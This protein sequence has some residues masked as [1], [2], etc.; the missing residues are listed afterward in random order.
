V[1]M[2]AVGHQKTLDV[3]S[4]YVRDADGAREGFL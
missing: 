4:G 2:R 1:E 3:L